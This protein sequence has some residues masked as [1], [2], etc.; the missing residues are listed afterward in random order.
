M[1]KS[2]YKAEV[3]S[4]WVLWPLAVLALVFA[5]YTNVHWFIDWTSCLIAVGVFVL[6]FITSAIGA[7]SVCLLRSAVSDDD[8]CVF[9]VAEAIIT[10]S[11]AVPLWYYHASTSR[12]EG[13]WTWGLPTMSLCVP[14]IITGVLYFF[15]SKAH[16]K[17]REA[18]KREKEAE[19]AEFNAL[20]EK[21]KEYVLGDDGVQ[22]FKRDVTAFIQEMNLHFAQQCNMR[23]ISIRHSVHFKIADEFIAEKDFDA[24]EK[25]PGQAYANVRTD[26]CVHGE[27]VP[28][29]F[30]LGV[31][32]R[33]YM[34]WDHHTKPDERLDSWQDLIP[35]IEKKLKA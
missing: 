35:A 10:A 24:L 8:S 33:S 28:L 4:M 25:K 23:Q 26:F 9:G 19:A 34:F 12:F 3:M 1:K 27:V 15:L 32:G 5:I 20:C 13:F 14:L 17:D 6:F 18:F 11:L 2:V 31:T 7:C 29:E 30:N 22:K 21:W 16:K